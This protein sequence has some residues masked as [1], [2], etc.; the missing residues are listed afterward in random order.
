MGSAYAHS[1][2]AVSIVASWSL[3][4]QDSHSRL[5]LPS[6][7][8]VPSRGLIQLHRIEGCCQPSTPVQHSD[9][10]KS[11]LQPET[12]VTEAHNCVGR[13]AV[14]MEEDGAMSRT[15]TVV[16]GMTHGGQVP[17]QGLSIVSGAADVARRVG[18]P[19]QSIH[20]RLMPVQ[21]RHRQRGIPAPSAAMGPWA[22]HPLPLTGP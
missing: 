3:E 19:C 21:L 22:A 16:H 14:Y 18:R 15:K 4:L 13:G 5:P 11:Q 6:R 7:P 17:Y 12:V 9:N 20:G 10:A 2:V 1:A 8:L